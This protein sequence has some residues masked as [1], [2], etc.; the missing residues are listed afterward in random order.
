MKIYGVALLA[1][2]FLAGKFLGT[3]LGKLI[4]VNGDVGGVGFAMLLL[5]S[6]NAW[7]N[8]KGGLEIGTKE[9]ILF[10]SGMYIPIIIAMAS[11]QNVKAALTGGPCSSSCRN[12]RYTFGFFH[13]PCSIENRKRTNQNR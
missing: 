7:V 10:W 11:T 9:G 13:C 6:I 8:K 1:F 5:I 3:L 12:N 2:C 4:D